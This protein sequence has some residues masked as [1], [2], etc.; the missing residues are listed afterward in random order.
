[1]PPSDPL[2][3]AL[4]AALS[5]EVRALA[6]S[7][8]SSVFM[9]M[10]AAFD[11]VVQQW[12][13]ADDILLAAA[14][15]NRTHR[16]L[17]DV[18]GCFTRQV[19]LRI[20]L[21]GDPTFGEAM[22]RARD[23]VLGALSHLDLPYDAI[24]REMLGPAG[25]PHGLVPPPLVVLQTLSGASGGP[26]LLGLRS[27]AL[28]V[29][30][31]GDQPP[32]IPKDGPGAAGQVRPWGMGLYGGSVLVVSVVEEPHGLDCVA[33]GAF[34][35]PTVRRLFD[36]Y[37]TVLVNA[38]AGPERRLSQLGRGRRSGSGP[39]KPP[40]GGGAVEMRGFWVEPG[41]IAAVLGHC[42]GIS[43]SVVVLDEA[44][45]NGPR[46]VAYVVAAAGGLVPSLAEVRRRLW[47]ELPGYAWPASV[48]VVPSLPPVRDHRL[49]GPPP[50]GRTISA[51]TGTAEA[52]L[53]SRLWAEARGVDEVPI[54]ESYWLS[55]SFLEALARARDA[56]L[57]VTLHQ[58]ASNRTVEALAVAVAVGQDR[59]SHSS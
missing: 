19:P 34:H 15:A 54:D 45:Q 25:S 17:H 7:R 20:D 30:P 48:V 51:G 24:L 49:L 36:D 58:V 10:L 38:V 18:I 50:E 1:M 52:R 28:E 55:F 14:I 33:S 11:V 16:T 26:S 21:A 6:R 8:R 3:L 22:D 41:R 43:E 56:G 23:T 9:T 2:R 35:P 32:G 12:T 37:R 59:V 31:T 13:G 46:L 29:A 57:A 27:E 39:P 4:G 5:S 53:L 42:P 47:V 40:H 44:P